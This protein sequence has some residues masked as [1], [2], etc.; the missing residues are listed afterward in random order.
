M[1]LLL[2]SFPCFHVFVLLALYAIQLQL[3]IFYFN[4]HKL[5]LLNFLR[6]NASASDLNYKVCVR[7]VC[8]LDESTVKPPVFVH[9][10][11]SIQVPEDADVGTTV[12]V[13]IK[14]DSRPVLDVT[15]ELN[16]VLLEIAD[17][18]ETTGISLLRFK[19][20]PAAD[21]HGDSN[22]IREIKITASID[23][24]AEP[25]TGETVLL[26]RFDVESQGV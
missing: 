13:D 19:E 8:I 20:K 26:V 2:L 14:A 9:P 3:S 25:L 22:F 6:A 5:H 4:F 18:S 23:S 12:S 21:Q 24:G 16:D 17:S 1:L 11:Y 7:T 15:Y 10:T